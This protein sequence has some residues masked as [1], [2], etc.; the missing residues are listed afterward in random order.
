LQLQKE[1]KLNVEYIRYDSSGENNLF[2]TA[3]NVHPH[4]HVKFEYTAQGNPQQ[5]GKIERKFATLYGKN[6]AMLNA[7]KFDWPSRHK[8]WAYS[9]NQATD[10]ANIIVQPEHKATAYELFYE[11]MDSLH[12][13]GEITSVRD[14]VKI[15]STLNNRG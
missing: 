14:P 11:W 13:F 12:K 7:A 2:Q 8:M 5:N 15:L 1:T 9:A 4:M 3:A 10:L 6:R